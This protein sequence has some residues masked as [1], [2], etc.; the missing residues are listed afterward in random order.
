[1]ISE[2]TFQGQHV[3]ITGA[4]R[5]LGRA[6]ALA[7]ARGGASVLLHYAHAEAAAQELRS[8][9]EQEGGHALAVQADLRHAQEVERLVDRARSA[10]GPLDVWINNAGASANTS[11][12]QGL[13]EEERFERLLQVDVMGTW[14]CCRGAAPL[15]RRGG[16]ILNMAWNHALDGATGFVSQAYATSKGAIISLSRCLAREL[17]PQVRVNCIAPGWIENEWARTRTAAFR[18]RV[19]QRIP[20][21]R[22]GRADDVVAAALFLASPAAAFVTGQVLVVDGGEVMA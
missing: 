22:W 4:A 11:E 8:L 5:G 2:Q 18:E 19:E 14:R 12:T 1:M 6:L 15:M 13:S 10:L 3:V 21:A 7:F 16:C 17:A 20:L 9:I